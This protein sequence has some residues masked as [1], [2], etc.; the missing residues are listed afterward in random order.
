M[1]P[2]GQRTTPNPRKNALET[3]RYL[4]SLSARKIQKAQIP[5]LLRI[6][7]PDAG[8]GTNK[9]DRYHLCSAIHQRLRSRECCSSNRRKSLLQET[10]WTESRLLRVANSTGHLLSYGDNATL[11]A[12]AFHPHHWSPDSSEA[13]S[14]AQTTAK[15]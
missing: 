4:D 3:A 6:I 11:A 14:A 10:A 7:P 2:F 1:S 15:S 12:P 5:L 8:K 9:D 13:T